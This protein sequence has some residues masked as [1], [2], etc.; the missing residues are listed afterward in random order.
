[1][2]CNLAHQSSFESKRRAKK[3]LLLCW[4]CTICPT[5]GW[6]TQLNSCF[7]S[8]WSQLLPLLRRGCRVFQPHTL[9]IFYLAMFS[10]G[11]RALPP[12]LCSKDSNS[13]VY[14]HSK[15]KPTA[16]ASQVDLRGGRWHSGEIQ[17]ERWNSP[18][19][20]EKKI[21]VGFAEPSLT[22]YSSLIF[23]CLRWMWSVTSLIWWPASLCFSQS[24]AW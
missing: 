17:E 3:C 23:W 13:V 15:L 10:S 5:E 19:M 11:N 12:P 7:R 16:A 9:A 22:F 8:Y 20:Q 2:N 14:C 21:V 6:F 24:L 4:Q 1:M 18:G